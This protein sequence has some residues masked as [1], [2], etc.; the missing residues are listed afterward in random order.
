MSLVDYAS[1]DA[2][3][4]AEV[5]KEEE[6]G[7]FQS[8]EDELKP[9]M[10]QNVKEMIDKMGYALKFVQVTKRV[11]EAYF[12]QLCLTKLDNEAESISFDL[13]PSDAINIAVRCK[14]NWQLRM[15]LGV[16]SV[17]MESDALSMIV[18]RS[19]GS[20]LRQEAQKKFL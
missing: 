15:Q 3:D 18:R 19:L 7:S 2:E 10:H 13:W 8:P 16:F 17:F 20:D 6:I 4:E 5:S 12:A 9:T 1:S 11:H 14:L